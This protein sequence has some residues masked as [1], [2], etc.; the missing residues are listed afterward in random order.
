[1]RND[2]TR[3]ARRGLALA[4]VVLVAIVTNISFA[5]GTA[6]EDGVEAGVA[7]VADTCDELVAGEDGWEAKVDTTGDPLTVE[8]T[9]PDGYLVDRY[10]VK[11]GSAHQ[12]DGPVIV[13]VDPPAAT[14][15]IAH[16]SGKAVS[17]YMVHLVPATT[18]TEEVT[19]TTEEVTT[20]TEA[21]TTTTEEV[22]TTTEAAT[23]T[24]AEVLGTTV[25]PQVTTTT[26]EATTTT[27]A[28]VLGVTVERDLPRTGGGL[29]LAVWGAGALGLGLVLWLMT[30]R[31]ATS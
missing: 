4:V 28:Q 29:V 9:A 30:R 1:M 3:H 11:A 6:A 18:T 15:V 8:Y 16:P 27:G 17:H 10:C 20:T 19:T 12:D 25:V 13:I 5:A 31:E 24:T 22:T 23:T 14:V 26:A 7:C 2:R 21:A